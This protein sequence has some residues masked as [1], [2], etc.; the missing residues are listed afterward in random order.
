MK[1]MIGKVILLSVALVFAAANSRSDAATATPVTLGSPR[2]TNKLAVPG[3]TKPVLPPGRFIVGGTVVSPLAQEELGLLTLN[4]AAGFVCSASL[5]NNEWALTAAH[6]VELTIGQPPTVAPVAVTLTAN[7]GT[8]QIQTAIQ[9]TTFRTAGFDVAIVRAAK[10]FVV[11]GS[12]SGFQ[13]LVLNVA[14]QSLYNYAIEFYG[15]GISQFASGSG[16]TATPSQSDGKFRV[17]QATIDS[18]KN[19]L[20]WTAYNTASVAG[21]DSGGPSMATVYEGR[22]VTGVHSLCQIQCVAGQTCGTWPGP[23]PAPAGYSPWRWVAATPA[24]ADAPVQPVW[25]SIWQTIDSAKTPV[26]PQPQQYV[27]AFGTGTPAVV[28]KQQRA[29]YA[30]NIDEPL[31]APAGAVINIPLTFQQ[32]HN[33]VTSRGCPVTQAMQHWSYDLATH[34]LLNAPSGMCLNI[35]GARRDAAGAPIILN[36]CS[37]LANE[38]WTVT[39]RPGT[40]VWTVK[41]DFNGMCLHAIPSR[42][43]ANVKVAVNASA[44]LVQMPCDGSEAEHFSDVDANW[45]RRNGPR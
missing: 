22:V 19:N 15:R 25:S 41:S 16:P 24:C 23:G 26:P 32:C 9:V 8:V 27:G 18:Y 3:S 40:A 11:L 10:P 36:P 7:W 42:R 4:T 34:R 14:P 17:A 44:T 6:C 33:L 30:M 2:I 1:T 37:G 43:G 28:M 35:S 39:A 29:L 45:S 31:V 5:L 12:I 20:N 21:G 38:K 13:R